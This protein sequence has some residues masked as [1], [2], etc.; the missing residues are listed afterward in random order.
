MKKKRINKIKRKAV[1][2][3]IVQGV[4]CTQLSISEPNLHRNN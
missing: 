2:W 4:Q 3:V 1:R